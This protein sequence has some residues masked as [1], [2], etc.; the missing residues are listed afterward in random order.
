[1]SSY[2]FKG[3]GILCTKKDRVFLGQIQ[4]YADNMESENGKKIIVRSENRFSGDIARIDYYNDPVL[5]LYINLIGLKMARYRERQWGE[6]TDLFL[7]Q[8]I[9]AFI[10]L[11]GL[12]DSEQRSFSFLE[13]QAICFYILKKET[14]KSVVIPAPGICIMIR[15]KRKHKFYTDNLFCE[16][17]TMALVLRDIKGINKEL[18]D[19][20]IK[21]KNFLDALGEIPEIIYDSKKRPH[22]AAQMLVEL[23]QKA[24]AGRQGSGEWSGPVRHLASME[25]AQSMANH[26]I[27]YPA[28]IEDPF[29]RGIAARLSQ[30]WYLETEGEQGEMELSK[31][32]KEVYAEY[33]R[34]G[35]L[36]IKKYGQYEGTAFRDNRVAIERTLRYISDYVNYDSDVPSCGR[37]HSLGYK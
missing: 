19:V 27:H 2:L 11:E 21:E 20:M 35:V 29:F 10:R 16:M 6:F 37:I 33:E 9:N 25:S 28:S 34:D 18:Y 3:T 31:L 30:K 5:I 1:M 12:S 14:Q 32:L 26:L 15:N 8:Y 23:L 7:S 17:T 4:K 36:Y 13:G 24:A 22:I